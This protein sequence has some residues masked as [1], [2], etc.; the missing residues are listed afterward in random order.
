MT[1][2]PSKTLERYELV[3]RIAVGGMAEVFRAVAYGAHGFEKPLAIKRILPELASDPE[4]ES[5]F[6]DEAKL[7]VKLTHANVVQVF[8]FGRFAGT[9]FI[10]MEYVDGLDLA[11][12]LK[13]Y[14]DKGL[15]VPVPAAFQIAIEIARGLDFAHMNDVVHRD[16][17][18]SNILLSRAGEVK[19]AD[20]GIAQA[21]KR[22]RR[23]AKSGRRRIMGK[24]R[25]MSPEQTT[26]DSLSP[27]S[28]LFSAATVMFELFTGDKLFP[29]DEAEAI[30]ANIHKMPI[31]R[32][33]ER[34]PGLPPRL[35]EILDRALA[36]DPAQRFEKPGLMARALTEISYESSIVATALDVAE[37]VTRILDTSATKKKSAGGGQAIDDLIRKQLG[38]AAP[39]HRRTAIDDGDDS[40]SISA[41][42][43]GDDDRV[44]SNDSV[45]AHTATVVRKGVDDDGLTL[46]EL[47]GDG[48]T[49]E[50]T[51]AAVPSAIRLGRQS[52]EV[53]AIVDD[54]PGAE[55]SRRGLL[56]GAGLLIVATA[57]GTSWLIWGRSPQPAPARIA[58]DGDAGG[59]APVREASLTIES[60]PS[61]AT[62]WLDGVELPGKTPTVTPVEPARPHQIELE[63]PGYRR[64]TIAGIT[65]GA[66]ES[67]PISKTLVPI[68]A[69]LKLTT[70]P[71]DARVK[72]GDELI[73]TTPLERTNLTPGAGQSLTI[74]KAGYQTI[75]LTVDLDAD[76]PTTIN[77]IL[78]AAVR[79]GKISLYIDGGWANVYLRG[80]KVGRAPDKGIALPVGKQRLRLYNPHSKKE[81]FLDV[82]VVESEVKYYRVK[83]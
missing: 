5:R 80:K 48:A 16:V 53:K 8:D 73:G 79:Y 59:P 74:S 34:R 42:D 39:A 75:K 12:L 19:I 17:S 41:T 26:G 50:N 65:L 57:I 10:A 51:I 45:D 49:T 61:G 18:P 83:W 55:R 20:F 13:A 29:G 37:T 47:E 62:V 6:I 4:F 40:E 27:Q 1:V 44:T 3:D 52:G 15:R 28:D 31:P 46:W 23:P 36:R 11:A 24:W 81:Q 25:Y 58:T 66:G 54:E 77:R 32:A 69:T 33:S 76:E 72:L 7:A 68:Q 43:I 14:R 70:E 30:I 22:H 38:G 9:L 67:F 64:A 2:P 21:A 60:I 35:D 82:V 78:R 71:A 56:I 63:T